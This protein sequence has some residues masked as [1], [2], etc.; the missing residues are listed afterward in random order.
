MAG[1]SHVAGMT[2]FSHEASASHKADFSHMTLQQDFYWNACWGWLLNLHCCAWF[3]GCGFTSPP[4]TTT[5][6]QMSARQGWEL[7]GSLKQ[8]LLYRS[9]APSFSS[10]QQVILGDGS[11]LRQKNHTRHSWKLAEAV[12]SAESEADFHNQSPAS[13]PNVEALTWF[14]FIACTWDQIKLLLPQV[15]AAYP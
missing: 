6:H 1:F 9:Q 14:T 2:G 13:F 3:W 4:Y 10:R 5:Q 12:E 15:F 8:E 11:Q 7:M